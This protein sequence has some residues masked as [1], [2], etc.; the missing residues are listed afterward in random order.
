M[1]SHYLLYQYA[2]F[3]LLIKGDIDVATWRYAAW[4][5]PIVVCGRTGSWVVD[6]P[7]EVMKTTLSQRAMVQFF[8]GMLMVA[9][10]IGWIAHTVEYY[11]IS[12]AF[13]I[14]T[15]KAILVIALGLLLA[16]DATA[17]GFNR[18]V[19]LPCPSRAKCRQRMAAISEK[20]ASC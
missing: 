11:G 3:I 6:T 16:L 10:A 8:M 18:W 20:E 17:T 4:N 9:G 13:N 19:R 7:P 14:A 12:D 2:L 15:M 5:R 1:I